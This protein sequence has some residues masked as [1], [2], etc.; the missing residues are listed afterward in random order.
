MAYQ[1]ENRTEPTGVVDRIDD[2]RSSTVGWLIAGVIAVAAI[3]GYVIFGQSTSPVT[4]STTPQV[5]NNVT[6]EQPAPSTTTTQD[7]L[8]AD[9]APSTTITPAPGQTAAPPAPGAPVTEPPAPAQAPVT[10]P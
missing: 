10:T 9:Q 8:P 2:K 5:E 1:T 4:T 3:V 6:I 7:A